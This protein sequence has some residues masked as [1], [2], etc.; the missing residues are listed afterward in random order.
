MESESVLGRQEEEGTVQ[1]TGAASVVGGADNFWEPGQPMVEFCF[2]RESSGWL[3]DFE[4]HQ[5]G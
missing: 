3:A 1:Q 2:S 4:I 5:L